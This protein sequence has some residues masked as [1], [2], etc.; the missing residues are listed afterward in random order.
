MLDRIF[1]RTE[2]H[3][4]QGADWRDALPAAEKTQPP[5]G[6]IASV[7]KRLPLDTAGQSTARANA[8]VTSADG[9][10]IKAETALEQIRKEN[11][12]R[13]ALHIEYVKKRKRA[14]DEA[15]IER[16][17]MQKHLLNEAKASGALEGCRF[18]DFRSMNKS[19]ED[20]VPTVRLETE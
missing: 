3:R 8:R 10:L 14:L 4:P 7:I 19:D 9:D 18:V 11:A 1:N 15:I 6:L 2:G 20:V 13:E 5:Q 17:R 16:E 12:E